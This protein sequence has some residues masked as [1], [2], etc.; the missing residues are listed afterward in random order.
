MIFVKRKTKIDFTKKP[1]S[2]LEKKK[3]KVRRVMCGTKKN[4]DS[5]NL[6][7]PFKKIITY[8]V[9]KKLTNRGFL[10]SKI[11]ISCVF[12]CQ[13]KINIFSSPNR[14]GIIS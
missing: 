3:K 12:F 7:P 9:K 11:I 14:C 2:Y 13:I 10:S 6:S 5:L 8:Y 4:I 1:H